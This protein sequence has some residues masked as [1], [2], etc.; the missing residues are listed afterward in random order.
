MSDKVAWKKLNSASVKDFEEWICAMEYQPYL[1]DPDL[2]SADWVKELTA[3]IKKVRPL[4]GEGA[5][6]EYLYWEK[7]RDWEFILSCLSI[8]GA[9]GGITI[10]K[11][12]GWKTAIDQLRYWIDAAVSNPETRDLF[13]S[14]THFFYDTIRFFNNNCELSNPKKLAK[15]VL[16]YKVSKAE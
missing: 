5:D 11:K 9:L 3:A 14:G 4:V 2:Q 6:I 7:L 16:A 10:D 12:L 15:E 13:Q 1:H 8:V